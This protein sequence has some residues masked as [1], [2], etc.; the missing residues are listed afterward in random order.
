MK[1]RTDKFGT[2]MAMITAEVPLDVRLAINEVCRQRR[3]SLAA[4]INEALERWLEAE[5]LSGEA[6]PSHVTPGR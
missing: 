4:I 6:Q 5:G 3:T 2:S 1:T